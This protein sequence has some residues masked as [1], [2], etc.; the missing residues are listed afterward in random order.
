MEHNLFITRMPLKKNQRYG[1]CACGHWSEYDPSGDKIT[2]DWIK[3][4][5]DEIKSLEQQVELYR[6]E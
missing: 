5:K 6:E 4:L 2:N 1:D 3:H